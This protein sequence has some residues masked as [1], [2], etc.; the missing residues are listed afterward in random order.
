MLLRSLELASSSLAAIREVAL[1]ARLAT[2]RHAP[3]PQTSHPAPESTNRAD[4][5]GCRSWGCAA[6]AAH[7]RNCAILLAHGQSEPAIVATCHAIGL[8]ALRLG[9]GM[10]R[11]STPHLSVPYVLSQ[12][13]HGREH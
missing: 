3:S 12:R 7:F 9:T 5:A 4:V 8:N 13:E 2:S 11:R 1:A 6:A 10:H